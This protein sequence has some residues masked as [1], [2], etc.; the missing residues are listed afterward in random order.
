MLI[1]TLIT[2]VV[3]G[4]CRKR[5]RNRK[6]EDEINK[7]HQYIN[8]C[9]R[10]DNSKIEVNTMPQILSQTNSFTK[11]N[12]IFQMADTKTTGKI[13]LEFEKSEREIIN[14]P[15]PKYAEEEKK[16]HC[17]NDIKLMKPGLKKKN[18]NIEIP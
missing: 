8:S 13:F 9:D 14:Q 16:Q 5:Q 12:R 11:T 1:L 6:L 3:V 2:V 17:E 4:M 18:L 10:K 15:S 7:L